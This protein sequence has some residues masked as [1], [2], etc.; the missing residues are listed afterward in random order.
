MEYDVQVVSFT[1]Q[2]GTVA[3]NFE[4]VSRKTD[5]KSL[6]VFCAYPHCWL[7]LHKV[8]DFLHQACQR[9]E[10]LDVLTMTASKAPTE[11]EFNYNGTDNQTNDQHHHTNWQHTVAERK[12]AKL[13]L[14]ASKRYLLPKT[15]SYGPQY[16]HIYFC[17]LR[18]LRETVEQSA[19]ATFGEANKT[20]RYAK[21]IVDAG[22]K[23]RQKG[24]NDGVGNGDDENIIKECVLIGVVF[25][26]MKG[27]PS[28]LAMYEQPSPN[29][30]IPEPPPRAA[31]PF[32]SKADRIFL[33]DDNARCA[34]EVSALPPSARDALVTGFVIAVRGKEDRSTGAFSVSG[35][36]S[37]SPA[38]QPQSLVSLNG[39][40]LVCLLSSLALTPIVPAHDLLLE[41]LRGT[42]D[43]VVTDSG[44]E[45]PEESEEAFAPSIV[46]AIIAG[47]IV[48]A[49]PPAAPIH[50]T[51]T[52][53]TRN[54]LASGLRDADAFLS[55]VAAALP[56][57]V[58][59]GSDD[60]TNA[61]LPQ[62]PLHRCLL[63][64]AAR[65]A[66][67]TR[68]P[69]P[70]GCSIEGRLFVG[71]SGQ[72]VDDLALYDMPP[73]KPDS[74]ETEDAM[75]DDTDG[76][77]HKG[78]YHSGGKKVL[79]I[80]EMLVTNRHLAPTCPDTLGAYPFTEMDP[81]VMEESPHVMFVGNQK[82]F[83][84]RVMKIDAAIAPLQST[85][86]SMDIDRA[87]EG[88]SIRLISIPRFDKTGQAV[89]VDLN[90]LNCSV[91]EFALTM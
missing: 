48:S 34:L 89:F 74:T 56:V 19:R 44:L 68:A 42:L 87:N 14:A 13:D 65:S 5:L 53:D 86:E 32:A 64:G 71:T 70:F 26:E 72:N 15:R 40:R 31:K 25:R 47:N 55:A 51:V 45:G 2:F 66:N 37:A 38:P 57:S 69:N 8:L 50:T 6:R 22:G 81:F 30:L 79:D 82:E 18:Q 24:E 46:H 88:S 78:E 52:P 10:K 91:R 21:G 29:H 36:A 90:S 12:T 35:I 39:P 1:A 4:V 58:M 43:V 16:S 76:K 41:A 75:K 3:A 7:C 27:K 54:R 62:Q 73:T 85:A 20:L 61:H 28:I 63:P 60:A 9:S 80:L 49:A 23:T 17:R 84:T 33:E 11:N 83:A 67:L 59:P 77:E